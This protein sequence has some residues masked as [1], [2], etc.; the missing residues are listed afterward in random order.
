[1]GDQADGRGV[2]L[3]AGV[4]SGDRCL[5]VAAHHHRPQ[6]GQPLQARIRPWVLVGVDEDRAL[7][8]VGDGHRHDLVGEV[9]GPLRRDRPLM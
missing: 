3:A 2:V 9:A 8:A 5:R 1:M 4:T 7:L 6:G